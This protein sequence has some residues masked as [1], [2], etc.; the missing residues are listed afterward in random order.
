MSNG[1]DYKK[2]SSGVDSIGRCMDE[3][4][5]K[6]SLQSQNLDEKTLQNAVVYRL[7]PDYARMEE[8]RKQVQ[9]ERNK[10]NRIDFIDSA[11]C[12]IVQ[13]QEKELPSAQ[14]CSTAVVVDIFEIF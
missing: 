4:K 13:K 8:L 5:G 6:G 2:Y 3:I 1:A 9:A 7:S 10:R 11:G 12:E 14:K